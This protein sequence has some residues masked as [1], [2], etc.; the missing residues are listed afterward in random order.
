MASH[1]PKASPSPTGSS[2]R[3]GQRQSSIHGGLSCVPKFTRILMESPKGS[4]AFLLFPDLRGSQGPTL[5]KQ[6]V[7]SE[8]S[9]D[10][11]VRLQLHHQ[12]L[13]LYSGI[14]L[15]CD[16]V[17]LD[18]VG[19]PAKPVPGRCGKPLRSPLGQAS[20]RE[21]TW[22]G[23]LMQNPGGPQESRASPETGGHWLPRLPSCPPSI[24]PSFPPFQE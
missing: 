22:Q 19:A 16:V 10:S 14:Y 6:V 12:E 15:E 1:G 2:G 20:S 9:E 11:P 17:E 8:H 13:Q 3:W 24:P 18:E 21:G 23:W 4:P 7:L 5:T